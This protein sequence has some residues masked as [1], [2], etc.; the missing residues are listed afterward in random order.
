MAKES[1]ITNFE[2]DVLSVHYDDETPQ[3]NE[4]PITSDTSGILTVLNAAKVGSWEIKL[5]IINVV[6]STIFIAN[7]SMPDR[8]QKNEEFAFSDFSA[9]DQTTINNFIDSL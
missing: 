8:E 5:F 6:E 1:I 3:Y 7:Q 9:E 4:A 2:Y